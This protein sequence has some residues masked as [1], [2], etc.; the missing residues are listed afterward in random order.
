MTCRSR[1]YVLST[2]LCPSTMED[3]AMLASWLLRVPA[4]ACIF[5]VGC[6]R[7]PSVDTRAEAESLRNIE[8]QWLAAT[9]ARDINGM[10]GL[11][12]TEGVA[13]DANAPLFVGHEAIRKGVEAW[14]VD[15]TVCRTFASEVDAVEVSA[16]GDLAYTR[17]TLRYSHYTP[18]GV[19]NE[20]GKWVTIY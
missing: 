1:F 12:A 16:S 11:Y 3:F 4:C 8:A 5:L 20:V 14:L 19:V 17:G 18:K 10:I 7:A 6:T 15:T 13:M 2:T 9:K